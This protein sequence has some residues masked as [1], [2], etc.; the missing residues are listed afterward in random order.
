MLRYLVA[1]FAALALVMGGSAAAMA[2]GGL[3]AA[4]TATAVSA[5]DDDLQ[6]E[7][8][9]EKGEIEDEIEDEKGELADEGSGGSGGAGDGTQQPSAV[10]TGDGLNSSNNST[11]LFAAAAGLF[12]LGSGA[13]VAR[14][15]S[16]K[17]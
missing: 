10:N 13:F 6:D 16:V 14:R 1:A 7:V 5:V 9:D 12:L 3:D 11:A 17:N 15:R 2:A 4:V 8:A